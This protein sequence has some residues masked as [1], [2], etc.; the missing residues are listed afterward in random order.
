ME[1]T[2]STEVLVSVASH[3]S[4]PY[5]NLFTVMSAAVAGGIT[6]TVEGHIVF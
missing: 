1:T 3:P 6:V 5:L 2:H 4:I